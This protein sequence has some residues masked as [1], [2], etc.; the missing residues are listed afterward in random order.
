MEQNGDSWT[1]SCQHGPTECTGNKQ[2]SCIL[3]Y[4]HDQSSQ[5]DIIHCIESS[6]DVV[7][8]EIIKAVSP[9]H[10]LCQVFIVL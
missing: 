7:S 6:N 10:G 5:M 3:N 9:N 1:F 8:E 2:Q 4:V